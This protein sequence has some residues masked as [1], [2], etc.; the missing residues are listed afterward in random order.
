M[1]N[2]SETKWY[3]FSQSNSGGFYIQKS[4]KGIDVHVIVEATSKELACNFVQTFLSNKGSCPC[5]GD[6]WDFYYVRDTYSDVEKAALDNPYNPFFP[7]NAVFV[8]RLGETFVAINM[9]NRISFYRVG[10]IYSHSRVKPRHLWKR[11]CQRILY[12]IASSK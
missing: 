1:F 7:S 3:K 9:N 10:H 6:R 2:N 11:L 12:N 4:E 8:N 5:C